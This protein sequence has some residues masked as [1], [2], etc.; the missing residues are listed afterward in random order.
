MIQD[1]RFG[2]RMLLKKPAFTLIAILTL[3]LGIGA[4]TAIFSIV[5]AVLLR[6]LPYDAPGQLVRLWADKSGQRTEQNHFSPAEITDFR[7]QLTTF[8]DIGLFDVGL[9]SNFTGGAQPE[10][11]NSAEASPSLFTV[12][13]AKPIL[14]RTFLPQETDIAQSKVV[15]ISEGLWKRHFGAETD[16]VGRAVQL[17]NESFTVVGVLPDN[18]KFP[19]QVDVWVPFSFTAADWQRDRSH[20]YV[21]VVGRLKAE[22]TEAQAKA[23]LETIVQRLKPGFSADKQNWGIT[24][25]PLHEQVV[26]KISPTLW[27]LFGAVGCILLIA[28]V[29]VANLLLTRAAARQKEMTI[30]VALGAGRVRLIRQLLTESLLLSVMGAGLGLGL[31][32]WAVKVF[33]VSFLTRLPRAETITVDSRVLFFTL[34]VALVTG[35]L[36]GLTPALQA[37]Q[38]NLNETLK[39]GGRQSSGS[40]SRLRNWLVVAEIALSLVL[41]LGAGLLI[42]SFLRLQNVSLGFDPHQVLTLQLTMPRI[43]YPNTERQNA[44]VQQTLQRLQTLPGVKSV[45]ATINLPLLN[46]WGMGYGVEGHENSP[47]QIADNANVTPNYFQTM[48]TPVLQGRDFSEHDTAAAPPVIIINEALARKHFPNENPLGQYLNMGRKREIVGVV[49]DVKSRGLEGEVNPQVYFPYA[50]KPTIAAFVTFTIRAQNDPLAL[51]PAIEKEIGELDK[52]LPVAN[53]R[54]MEQVIGETLAQR[55]L[56]M[57]LLGGF[58]LLALMLAAVGVYGVVS[59]TVAQRTHEIGIRL[60]L[61]AQAPEVLKMVIWQAMKVASLGVA[62]GLLNAFWL[63]KVLK[64]LLFEVSTTD[65]LTYITVAALS[66]LVALVACYI[67]A[68]RATKVDPLV[69]LRYE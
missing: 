60:A 51:R 41:L 59:Y 3:G 57:G 36:F 10:R 22:V 17:D 8:D 1:I 39:E 32:I 64:T 45:A 47:N 25:I 53:V 48:G 19:E 14:G 11:V 54:T 24:L 5:N 63:M 4:T 69:A 66:L 23:E 67:P 65:P 2:L 9:S 43:K 68:R 44:F 20:Y 61:G 42:K 58:A 46:T 37:S 18:F 30:R 21:E 55:Q 6:P 52:D 56:T 15:L 40:R 33:S 29:N 31:A 62:L 28:C 27:I 26:G 49:A 16:I 12:L 7:E 38:P 13:R 35:T 34:A 50:Q